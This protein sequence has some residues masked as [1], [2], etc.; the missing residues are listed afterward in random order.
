MVWVRHILTFLMI[1]K[2]VNFQPF[3]DDVFLTYIVDLVDLIIAHII[4]MS[5]I[6]IL[7][8]ICAQVVLLSIYWFVQ[9][10]IIKLMLSLL[11]VKCV[12][13]NSLSIIMNVLISNIMY[14]DNYKVMSLNFYTI[15]VCERKNLLSP[16]FYLFELFIYDLHIY[17][18]VI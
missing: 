3:A 10:S 17:T 16:P 15:C 6:N 14:L 11:I 18:F 5:F 4:S 1:I 12:H 9:L 2:L 13:K 8:G 7:V